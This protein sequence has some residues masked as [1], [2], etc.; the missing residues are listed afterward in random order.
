MIA[1]T[2]PAVSPKRL[3]A[4]FV[5]A[6]LVLAPAGWIA[7][8]LSASA[9]LGETVRSQSLVL[10]ALRQRLAA[11]SEPGSTGSLADA[12]SLYLPGG[13]PAI[14]GAAL[15]RIVANAIHA[16]GGRLAESEFAPV[17]PAAGTPSA[18]EPGRVNLRVSFDSEVVG[19]QRIIYD[20]ENGVPIL[21]LQALVVQSPAAIETDAAASPPLRVEMLVGGYWEAAR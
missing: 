9:I 4:L 2:E 10:A 11:L 1:P 19:L 12:A 3:A 17:E 18:D 6:L 5:L 15:Q 14:A 21:T 13:T 7:W 16:G 8:S 20:L